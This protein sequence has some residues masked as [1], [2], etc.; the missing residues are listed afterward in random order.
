[1]TPQ[2][3]FAMPPSVPAG[4]TLELARARVLDGKESLVREWMQMLNARYDECVATL[5]VERAAFE[6]WFLRT[7][8][9]GRTWIYHVGLTGNDGAPLDVDSQLDA[10]HLAYAKQVKEKGW[11]RLEPVFLLAPGHIMRAMTQ[12]GAEGCET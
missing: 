1:M 10:D 9:D 8:T 6:A 2:E 11:E 5:A 4:M 7:E 12:W 3:S